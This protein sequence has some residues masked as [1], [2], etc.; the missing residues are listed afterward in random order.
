MSRPKT[1][2]A[3]PRPARLAPS[4]GGSSSRAPTLPPPGV[5]PDDVLDV[6]DEAVAENLLRQGWEPAEKAA[7]ALLKKINTPEPD[8]APEPAKEA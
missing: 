5:K 8:T 2:N 7:E 3:P 6:K 4:S 1:A